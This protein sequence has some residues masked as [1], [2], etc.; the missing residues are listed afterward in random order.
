MVDRLNTIAILNVIRF[1]IRIP[2]A[3]SLQ[4]SILFEVNIV[5]ATIM[6]ANYHT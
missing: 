1:N 3:G 5:M 4:I 2:L 6:V